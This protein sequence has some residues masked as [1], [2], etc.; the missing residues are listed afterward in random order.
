[1]DPVK[2]FDV[3]FG[4]LFVTIGVIAMLVGGGLGVYF[5]RRPPRQQRTLLF[6]LLP[7]TI[8]LAFCTVGGI[9]ANS[10]LAAQELERRLRA[11]GVTAR[12]QVVEIERTNTRLN[13]SYLWHIRY[14]YRDP[15]GRVYAGV[16][17]YLER[18]EAQ[19]FKV[20]D[21]GI[22]RYDPADPA[23]SIWLGREERALLP[24]RT[25]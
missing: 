15:T 24:D 2:D 17:G 12:A 23:S 7:L 6:L 10:G 25:L 21:Q 9:F 3:W 13:G 22:V 1:V 5:I 16:S 18:A 4:A 11:E 8:G 14:E 19:S 20:G